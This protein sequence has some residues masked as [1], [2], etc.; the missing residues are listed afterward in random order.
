[1]PSG[2]LG[3]APHAATP[4]EEPQAAQRLVEGCFGT[5]VPFKR[6][7]RTRRD[8][9]REPHRGSTVLLHRNFH[10]GAESWRARELRE[11]LH[12]QPR[13][14][15]TDREAHRIQQIALSHAVRAGNAAEPARQGNSM[16][17]WREG[18]EVFQRDGKQNDGGR[19]GGGGGGGGGRRS[20]GAA[21]AFR[22]RELID[23]DS[24]FS[25]G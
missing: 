21:A 6:K 8:G 1:M 2:R 9:G 13:R 4:Q 3:Y 22:R 15:V 24:N 19:G 17:A 25:Q 18:F 16:N 20:Y 5:R 7:N 11:G 14:S 10:V 12:A 23:Q